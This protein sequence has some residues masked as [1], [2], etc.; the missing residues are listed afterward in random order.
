MRLQAG[1]TVTGAAAQGPTVKRLSSL[2]HYMMAR[3]PDDAAEEEKV[4]RHSCQL[5][6]IGARWSASQKSLLDRCTAN[7]VGVHKT[8]H[9]TRTKRRDY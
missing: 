1:P 5:H 6:G 9:R 8:L 2:A 3:D 7:T 4:G